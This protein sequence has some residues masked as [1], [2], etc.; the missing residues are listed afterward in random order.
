MRR[1][2][3]DGLLEI[4]QRASRVIGRQ[5]VHEVDVDVRKARRPREL[6]GTACLVTVVDAPERA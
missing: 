5:G 2:E 3:L 6:H 1:R 4:R